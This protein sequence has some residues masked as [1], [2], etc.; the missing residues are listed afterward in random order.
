MSKSREHPEKLHYTIN[1]TQQ[2]VAD[3]GNPTF[4]IFKESLRSD[5]GV[6]LFDRDNED[7]S[8]L[9]KSMVY[10]DSDYGILAAVRK[11]DLEGSSDGFETVSACAKEI[12]RFN[13][14]RLSPHELSRPSRI[15]E[16]TRDSLSAP[17]LGYEGEDLAACLYYMHE[18]KDPALRP[19][20]EEVAAVLPEFEGFEFNMV[21]VER[22]AFS[23]KF[24][25]GRGTINSARMSHGNLLF[26]GLMVLTYTSNRPP[27]ML[28]EEPENG[29]TPQAIEHF[30]KA[31][32]A[33]ALREDA[34]QRS[35]VLISSHSPFVICEAWNGEDRDFIHQLKIDNGQCVIRRFS[36]VIAQGAGPLAKNKSGTRTVLGLKNASELMSGYLQ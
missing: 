9:K 17:R 4:Q 11:A 35:Q 16:I 30:Y 33:L 15:P 8:P 26:L 2:G 10:V 25:D 36:Q 24:S 7:A 29:L 27:V 28:L 32:R 1:Y 22:V 14:F 13:R 3:P 5:N 19:I 6:T 34:A 23:M 31:V 18:S 12:G 20:I 21:G